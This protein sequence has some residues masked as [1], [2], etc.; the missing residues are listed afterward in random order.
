MRCFSLFSSEENDGE[1]EEVI[2]IEM[3]IERVS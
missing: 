3:E 1:S 2:E